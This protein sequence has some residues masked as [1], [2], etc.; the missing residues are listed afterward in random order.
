[1]TITN[2]SENILGLKEIIVAY[3]PVTILQDINLYLRKSEVVTLLGA[4][5][6][7]KTT[8]LRAVAGLFP[9][10][11]GEIIFNGQPINGL[12]PQQIVALGI[13]LIPEGRLLF[14]TMTVLDNLRLGAYHLRGKS[15][16]EEIEKNLLVIFRLFPVLEKR[17]RQRAGTLSGG[18]QQMVAV[19]RGLMSQPNLL[20][21]DEPSMGLAPLVI[22]ELMDTLNKLRNEMGMS[23]LLAEQNAAAALKIADRG[24]VLQGGK[25]YF[26]GSKEELQASGAIRAAYLGKTAWGSEM[27]QHEKFSF[28]TTPED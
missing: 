10:S 26:E 16:K 8:L 6:M 23:V 7:G 25:I 1:M 24:Y 15:Q 27:G 9:P 3:G 19:G 22:V 18:E 20:L 21:L 17:R 11:S 12:S 2:R 14:P 13:A 5:G 28:H 4:N